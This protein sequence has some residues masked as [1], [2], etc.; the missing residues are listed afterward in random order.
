MSIHLTVIRIRKTG[1][2]AIIKNR[3]FLNGENFLNYLAIIEGRGEGL[4]CVFHE[5]IDLEITWRK[6]IASFRQQAPH[7][8]GSEAVCCQSLKT[9]IVLIG[10]RSAD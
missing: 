5:D 10:G 7:R 9:H 8:I 6:K 2:F 4:Y 3:S 1:Q